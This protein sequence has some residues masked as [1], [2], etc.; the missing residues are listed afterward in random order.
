MI[1]NNKDA[2]ALVSRFI[3]EY[4]VAQPA[5]KYL[6]NS[7]KNRTNLAMPELKLISCFNLGNRLLPVHKRKFGCSPP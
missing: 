6:H 2:T 4:V 7:G 1:E 5:V 3:I